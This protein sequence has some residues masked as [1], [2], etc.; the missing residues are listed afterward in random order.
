[1][2]GARAVPAPGAVGDVGSTPGDGTD[3]APEPVVARQVPRPYHRSMAPV[4][5]VFF[6]G[7]RGPT[8]CSGTVVQD[9]ARPGRSDLVWTAGHCVHSGA[10][11]QWMRNI[12]FVPAY[13]DRGLPAARLGAAPPDEVSP[14]GI[15]WADWSQ[16]SQGWLRHGGERGDATGAAHDFAVLHVRP[17]GAEGGSLEER[18]GAAVP[19]W[20]GAPPAGRISGASAYGYPAGAPFDGARMFRCTGPPGRLAAGRG[21]PGLYRIGCTMTGGA[22]GG[23][24]FVDREGT[25]VLV[26]NSAVS[27]TRHT[28]LAGPRLGHPARAVYDAVS[29]RFAGP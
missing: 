27:S 5:K 28:W 15:W 17:E 11:G 12:V 21:A 13:N 26:S 29:E 14:Y 7:P 24:W 2:A 20:F 8:V 1:M 19:V 10:R 3:P 23:G 25:T 18:V 22:S 4:G 9:P 6:D 16:T